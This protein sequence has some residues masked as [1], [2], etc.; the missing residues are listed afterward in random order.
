M[1]PSWTRSSRSWGASP[2]RC[3]R[4]SS[5]LRCSRLQG[6]ACR[7]PTRAAEGRDEV[8]LVVG[9]SDMAKV[10]CV[11]YDDP[12]DGYPDSYPRD[13]IPRL[14]RYPDGQTL[15]SPREIDFKPGTLLGS[16]S[17]ELGL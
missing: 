13:E 4:D 11:L 8:P 12:V 16:C 3:P 7:P 9:A 15:P 6:S 14:A 5:A 2:A 10:I 17:G 1:G